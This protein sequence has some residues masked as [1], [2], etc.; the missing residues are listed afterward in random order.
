MESLS[1][2]VPSDKRF[3]QGVHPSSAFHTPSFDSTT[4]IADL[5]VC[6]VEFGAWWDQRADVVDNPHLDKV[7]AQGRNNEQTKYNNWIKN[8]MKTIDEKVWLQGAGMSH[9]LIRGPY[10]WNW[11]KI[12]RWVQQLIRNGRSD[13]RSSWLYAYRD[14]FDHSLEKTIWRVWTWSSTC[15]CFSRPNLNDFYEAS[16]K[17]CWTLLA[18]P[19]ISNCKGR[20]EFLKFF[21]VLVL[22][23]SELNTQHNVL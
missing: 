17:R 12:P 5:K 22:L 19:I 7:N 23:T 20:A 4:S 15:G 10:R 16:T 3:G 9:N 6:T 21:F 13:A 8:S 1:L 11:S 2:W 18:T 14:C